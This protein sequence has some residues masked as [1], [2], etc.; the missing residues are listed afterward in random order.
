MRSRLLIAGSTVFM[1]GLV[2][3]LASRHLPARET[4]L[5]WKEFSWPFGRDGWPAGRAFQCTSPAC[6]EGA[7]VFVRPKIGF[8]NCATGVS[9]DTEVDR[10]TDLDLVSNRFRPLGEGHAAEFAGLRGRSR[11]YAIE[12]PDGTA[13]SGAAIAVSSQCDV[14]TAVAHSSPAQADELERNAAEFLSSEKIS[15][16]IGFTLGR[17]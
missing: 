11:Y 12:M 5:L 4:G 6:G 14:V 17:S 7:I 10:V 13:R 1:L 9:D 2:A 8:C 15:Q 16:W 3:G